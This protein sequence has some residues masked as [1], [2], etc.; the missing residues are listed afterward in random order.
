MSA[1]ISIYTYIRIS[2]YSS[3]PIEMD[4]DLFT[5]CGWSG[6]ITMSGSWNVFLSAAL[7]EYLVCHFRRTPAYTIADIS[8]YTYIRR[9]VP[10]GIFCQY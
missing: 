7:D 5:V 6:L 4:R 9:C 2:T 10:A 8:I 1:D 3:I